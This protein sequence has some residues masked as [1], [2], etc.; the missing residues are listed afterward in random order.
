MACA[1]D[2]ASVM[3][4]TRKVVVSRL[5]GS[6]MHILGIHCMAY[7]LELAFK[8]AIKSY[9]MAK[10]IEDVLSGLHTFYC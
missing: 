2:G 6:N 9:S 1:T 8:D 4:G 3:T 5:R 10:Q 7:R